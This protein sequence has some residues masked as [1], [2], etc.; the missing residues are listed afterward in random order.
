MGKENLQT[1]QTEMVVNE[2]ETTSSI[3]RLGATK[4]KDRSLVDNKEFELKQPIISFKG[5]RQKEQTVHL[6][7]KYFN[8]DSKEDYLIIGF[9]TEYCRRNKDLT[10]TYQT[11]KDSYDYKKITKAKPMGNPIKYR[12][13]ALKNTILSYQYYV[14]N[15]DKTTSYD[16]IVY[17][18]D[19][20]RLSIQE[21]MLIILGDGI[22]EHDLSN[23]PKKIYLVG[24]FTRAD[25]PSF[26]N[27]IDMT[28][29]INSI[30]SSFVTLDKQNGIVKI[31]LPTVDSS[32][33]SLDIMIRD[34]MILAPASKHKLQD[35]GELVGIKKHKI[36]DKVDEQGNVIEDY[37][38]KNMDVYM[39]DYPLEFEKYGIRDA[40]IC[41]KYLQKI[42][43]R[44]KQVTLE[45]SVPLT[46]SGIG[47][48]TLLKVWEEE[49]IDKTYVLGKKAHKIMNFN[50]AEGRYKPYIKEVW[51]PDVF[52]DLE[53]VTESFH[54]GRNEQFWYGVGFEDDWYDLD[55]AN[56]YPT[57]M[58]LIGYPK[59]EESIVFQNLTVEGLFSKHSE[60]YLRS[61]TDK[62]VTDSYTQHDRQYYEGGEAFK[63][64][65]AS[66]DTLM[67]NVNYQSTC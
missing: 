3:K 67:E 37:Y 36:E 60:M 51:L 4:P 24:H 19:D 65:K 43:D 27:F 47:V 58:S 7:S 23:I 21:F 10:L 20:K 41:V 17:V 2:V 38:I 63:K 33:Q 16:G 52:H 13:R 26:S 15:R 5:N 14:T 59:W 29:Y 55:L 35:L 8:N 11:I 1:K 34:T 18:D 42:M 32:V 50:K 40:E 9:D 49:G 66:L 56:A 46:L 64:D 28:K 39:K 45:E 12:H 31:E 48:T 22:L 54:G 57:A 25:I 62:T 53:F 6:N 30:R 61:L 44:F